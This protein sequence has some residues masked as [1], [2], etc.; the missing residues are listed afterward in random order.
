MKRIAGSLLIAIA[1]GI[2]ALGA[3]SL[4]SKN[5]V[6]YSNYSSQNTPAYLASMT[7]TSGPMVLPDF[8][9]A[10]NNTIHAVVHIKTEYER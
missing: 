1:G 5:E 4:I 3:Y 2:I 6:K 7:G 9:V 10:A 8:T